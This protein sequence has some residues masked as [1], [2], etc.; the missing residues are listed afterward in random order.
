MDGVYLERRQRGVV[1]VNSLMCAVQATDVMLRMLTTY[2]H[3]HAHILFHM[4]LSRR[5]MGAGSADRGNDGTPTSSLYAPEHRFFYQEIS[6]FLQ[7]TYCHVCLK[8]MVGFKEKLLC[9]EA[10]GYTGRC[11]FSRVCHYAFV[12][13]F[14]P[15]LLILILSLTLALILSLIGVLIV[16]LIIMFILILILVHICST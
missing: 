4:I 5:R 1:C 8:M 9:C 12:V 11:M 2:T 7:P 10:C 15:F 14:V 3:A 6:L 16:M 13:S